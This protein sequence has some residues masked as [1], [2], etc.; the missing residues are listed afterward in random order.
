MASQLSGERLRALES[1]SAISG[2]MPL[3]PNQDAMQS[4]GSYTQ[5][6]SQLASAKVVGLQIN[7]GD[8]LTGM[9]WI[10]HSYLVTRFAFPSLQS[11]MR[12]GI[13]AHSR[14]RRKEQ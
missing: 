3:L 14:G 13:M 10:V 4:R 7:L 8:E 5:F 2:L 9:W 1:R 12:K 11:K 6:G